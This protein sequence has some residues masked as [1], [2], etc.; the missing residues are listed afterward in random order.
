MCCCVPVPCPQE[1]CSL[2][3]VKN[4]QC[5]D[6]DTYIKCMKALSKKC[7]G[8]IIYHSAIT[9][10]TSEFKKKCNGHEDL[11]RNNTHEHFQ[12]MIPSTINSTSCPILFEDKKEHRFCGLFGDPHLRTFDGEYQTCRIHGAWQVIENPFFGIM[13]TNDAVYNSSTATAPTKVFIFS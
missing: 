10:S 11:F 9:V 6:L 5:K 8:D 2:I 12:S 3:E 13:V 4:S 1:S 7:R